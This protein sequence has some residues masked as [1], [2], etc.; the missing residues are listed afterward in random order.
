[1]TDWKV[2]DHHRTNCVFYLLRRPTI[3]NFSK[4]QS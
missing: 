4:A 1:V 2:L 3:A